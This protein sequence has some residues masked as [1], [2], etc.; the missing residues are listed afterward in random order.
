MVLDEID[1]CVVVKP[2]LEYGF[3]GFKITP[4]FANFKDNYQTMSRGFSSRKPSIG[5]SC[6]AP[7]KPTPDWTGFR[8]LDRN[9]L[10]ALH[11]DPIIILLLYEFLCQS[12]ANSSGLERDRK[13]FQSPQVGEW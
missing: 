3:I 7:T 12:Y 11:P 9:L 1:Q 8:Y 5:R 10:S 6:F 2:S 4:P 13:T